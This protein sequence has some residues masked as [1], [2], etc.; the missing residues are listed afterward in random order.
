MFFDINTLLTS[1]FGMYAL[2]AVVHS[3]VASLIVDTAIVVWRVS[4]PVNKQGLRLMALFFPVSMFPIYQLINPD[5]GSLYFRLGSLT[6]LNKWLYSEVF[7]VPLYVIALIICGLT[8]LVFLL[9]ELLPMILQLVYQGR[10]QQGGPSQEGQAQEEINGAIMEKITG[11]L[12]E[13]PPVKQG[14][15]IEVIDSDELELFSSTGL[16]PKIFITTALIEAFD[17]EH[18]QAAI[19]HE[20]GHILR[21]RRPILMLAYIVRT[22]VFFNPIA[23]IEFRK[24]AQEEEK[25]C[26]DIAVELTNNPEALYEALTMMRPDPHSE[27]GDGVKGIASSLEHYSHDIMLKNRLMRIGE[28]TEERAN[29]PIVYAM[30]GILIVS[31]NYFIV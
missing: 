27:A 19:A 13:L 28:P 29:I 25:I 23:L 15:G 22:L 26:D 2:Q 20:V 1:Y 16:K 8:T 31:L 11:A 10:G 14:Y 5:R 3:L 9:Q 30:T 17:K 6:D 18:L 4:K 7:G 12:K 24:I 21:S